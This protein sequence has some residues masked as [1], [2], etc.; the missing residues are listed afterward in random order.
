MA[1]LQGFKD[2]WRSQGGYREFF[3]LAFPLILSTASWSIQN[4]VERM[5]LTWYSAETIAAATP[6]GILNFTLMSLF[7]GTASY[8]GTFVAQY[9][10]AG[11]QRRI[12]PAVWQGIYVSLLGAVLIMA[13]IPL[14]SPVFTFI[15]HD[16]IV[17]R[18]EI[19]YFQILCLAAF[20]VIASSAL[21]G[22]FSGLGR[23]WPVMW[24]NTLTTVVS[25]FTGYAMIFGHWGA[26]ELGIRGAAI[27]MIISGTFSFVCYLVLILRNSEAKEYDTR[28][29]WA[30]DR[31]LFTRILRFGFPSGLQFCLDMAGFTIFVLLIGRLG[32]AALAATNIAFNINTLAFMPMLGSGVAVSVLVGQYLG[33]NR[34]DLARKSTY[35]GLKVTV[36][37]MGIIA[38]LYVLIPHVFVDAFTLRSQTTEMATIATLT[39]VLL[40]FVALYSLFD[41]LSIIIASAL[42]GAGDTR[43]VML[44]NVALS[45]LMVIPTYIIVIHLKGGIIPCW[46]I[47]TGYI[48]GMGIIFLARFKG[49][50]W[51]NMRVIEPHVAALPPGCAEC[52]DARIE[53]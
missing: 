5:F 18:Y 20:P 48:V 35:T 25:L 23:P 28:A 21:A 17:R 6:A 43:F 19:E 29:G 13:C 16:E 4:F 37:Y 49:G 41:G 38:A 50:A 34:P 33:K 27:A 26:P 52:P 31:A 42:K 3:V 1:M 9:H 2:R 45:A 15:G 8:V 11:A 53:S 36:V 44:V 32:T 7:I 40:R 46:S 10:G 39:V 30:F 22:F 47:A 24:I 12:G 14:A 51:Q